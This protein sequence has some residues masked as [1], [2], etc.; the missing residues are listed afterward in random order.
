MDKP[1]APVLVDKDDFEDAFEWVSGDPGLTNAAYINRATGKIKWVGEGVEEEEED[2]EALDAEDSEPSFDSN[3]WIDVPHK[4]DL[5]LGRN[6]V[7]RFID[8]V[9]PDAYNQVQYFFKR[10]GAYGRLKELLDRRGKLEEWYAYQNAAQ[11]QAL[12]RWAEVAGVVL[13]PSPRTGEEG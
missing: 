9:L 5:D 7:F 1:T 6:V 2:E 13:V 11:E 8:E 12:Q 4:H 3:E 10:R